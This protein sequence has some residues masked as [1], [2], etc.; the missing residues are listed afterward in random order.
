MKP[1]GRWAMMPRLAA[2]H[3]AHG[4]T[5]PPA[6]RAAFRT[7]QPASRMSQQRAAKSLL[8]RASPVQFALF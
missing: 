1:V 8:Q 5:A 7:A 4:K 2:A 6:R 3:E